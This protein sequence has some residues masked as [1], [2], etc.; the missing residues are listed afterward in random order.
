[1]FIL[2]HGTLNSEQ[3]PFRAK[4]NRFVF[5][6]IINFKPTYDLDACAGIMFVGCVHD[7]TLN[8]I[9]PQVLW[10]HPERSVHK[11]PAC[12][13]KMHTASCFLVSS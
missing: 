8:K 10:L 11:D 3:P 5:L 4:D 12:A 6:P 7:Y 1:M 9:W 13:R 2:K